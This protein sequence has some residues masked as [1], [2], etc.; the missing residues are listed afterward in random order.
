MINRNNI[1]TIDKIYKQVNENYEYKS[2]L[3]IFGFTLRKAHFEKSFIFS[4]ISKEVAD[5][6]DNSYVEDNIVY[7]KPHVRID[8]GQR[9]IFK[10]FETAKELDK[11]YV[12]TRAQT[13]IWID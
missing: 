2:E 13:S 6:D 11:W 1:I 3:K 12:E 9:Y 8:V 4:R 5:I 10:Y 7:Y